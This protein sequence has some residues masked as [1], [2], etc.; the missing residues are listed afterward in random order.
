MNET[1]LR[2]SSDCLD[3][4][5]WRYITRLVGGILLKGKGTKSNVRSIFAHFFR[6][7]NKGN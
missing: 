1:G 4:C 2:E 5:F 3:S 6:V 7:I